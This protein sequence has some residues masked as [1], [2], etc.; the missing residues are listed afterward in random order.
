MLDPVHHECGIAAVYRMDRVLAPGEFESGSV[1]R[2]MPDML[3]DLQNRGQ[4]AAGLTRY[5]RSASQILDTYK[6]VGS[7]TDVFHLTHPDTRRFEAIVDE[8]QGQAAI[9]HVRYATCGRD[10]PAYAQPFERHDGRK[11]EWF[12]FGFNGNIANYS[13]L[14]AKLLAKGDYHL[15]RETDTELLMH[16]LA[17]ALS[18]SSDQDF[19]EVFRYIDSVVDGAYCVAFL[20]A[21]GDLVL[22][23]DPR[24][25]RPLCY[26]VRGNTFAAASESLPLTNKGFED[27]KD[28]EPGCLVHVRPEGYEIRRFA[29]S[30]RKAYCFFEWVY[31]ANVA[32]TINDR[33]VYVTR[34]RLGEALAESESV[35]TSPDDCVAVPV[36]D[37]A[38]AACD[39]M[40]Y[41]LGIPSREGLIRNRYVGRTFIEGRNRKERASRKYTALPEVLK[42][43]RVFLVEDSIVRSTTLRV[44]VK[45]IRERGGA[46]EVHIRVSCPPIMAPC[47]YGIDM[48]TVSEL[49]APGFFNEPQ[50]EVTPAAQLE[51]L[52][53][54]LGTDSLRYLTLDALTAAIGLPEEDLCLA[55]LL[56]KYPTPWGGRLYQEA[57]R[58]RDRPE[59]GRTHERV[60]G[61]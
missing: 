38:K 36:P 56:G 17:Y 1:V 32:S 26:G 35:S 30:E 49:I 13:E 14:R 44:I 59:A 19:V 31:F 43:K 48:S 6:G 7:V 3:I 42:G 40:A 11:W 25:F 57:L 51:E 54:E 27:V 24:G 20:N 12:A 2:M 16:L 46:K 15:V 23:R 60:I 61:S 34:T 45:M 4:L 50:R 58:T 9:G 39:G 53:Q 52:A 41:K 29:E 5:N 33:S 22:A 10:D 28:L 18:H 47:S 55:C 37:T 8:Y 21:A